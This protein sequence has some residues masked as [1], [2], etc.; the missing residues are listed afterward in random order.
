MQD[1]KP[2]STTLPVNFKLSS[3]IC[4]NN[5]GERKE[6]S[7]VP[8]ASVVGSLMFAIICTSS[9]IAQAVGVVSRCM[10][11]PGGEHWKTVKRIMRYI[12]RSSDVTVC[13]R[14]SEFIG[15]GYVDSNFA[16]D[17]DKTKSATSYVLHL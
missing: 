6:R 16:E 13:Y 10:V 8:Y 15:R 3:S 9:D 12:R 7:Q 4:P 5:E 17:F 11:N 14:G 1:C 2:I